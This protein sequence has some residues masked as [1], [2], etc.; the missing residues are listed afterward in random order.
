[1]RRHVKAI[2][3]RQQDSTL[4]CSLAERTSVLSV[5]EPG[6]SGH[7]TLRRNPANYI[8]VFRH[9]A[10]QQLQILARRFLRLSEYDITLTDGGLRKYFSRSAVADREVSASGPV[11]LAALCVML[12]H[13]SCT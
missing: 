4:G 3:R 1:M 5:D 12:D 9:E 6:E 2:T 8:A 13:P 10:F 7:A 11:L